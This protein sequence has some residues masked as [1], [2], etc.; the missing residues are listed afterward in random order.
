[1][2]RYAPSSK[3]NRKA[4][5]ADEQVPRRTG[6]CRGLGNGSDPQ[7]PPVSVFRPA[8][9]N[10]HSILRP[11]R[12]DGATQA[13]HEC[14]ATIAV[15]RR[16]DA[17]KT[18]QATCTHRQHAQN[19]YVA[20]QPAEAKGNSFF[21]CGVPIMNVPVPLFPSRQIAIAI[22]IAIAI[23]SVVESVPDSKSPSKPS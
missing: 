9:Q 17:T 14:L 16:K 11:A 7:S 12:L 20:G 8:G 6:P 15:R 10:P 2:R 18:I 3:A 5:T 13:T 21:P 1:M 22:G 23:E 19:Q 4:R